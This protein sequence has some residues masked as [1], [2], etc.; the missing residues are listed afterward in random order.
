VGTSPFLE[1]LGS[2]FDF[3]TMV[4]I[5]GLWYVWNAYLSGF[6]PTTIVQDLVNNVNGLGRSSE[7]EA[8]ISS[9]IHKIQEMQDSQIQNIY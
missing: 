7:M 8:Q 9:I 3:S 1:G 4:S 6:V 2:R 5:A